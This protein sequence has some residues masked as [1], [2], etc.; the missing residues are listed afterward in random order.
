ML[1]NKNIIGNQR[2]AVAMITVIFIAII[3]TIITTSFIRLSI[4]EQRESTDDDL[5]TRA[6]YAAESGVQDAIAAIKNGTALAHADECRPE[7]GDGVLSTDLNTAY[8]CQKIDLTPSN[9]QASLGENKSVFFVLDSG[10]D[11]ITSFT[12]D[13]HM[14][15]DL[16]EGTNS[17]SRPSA[18]TGLPPKTDWHDLVD[19]TKSFPAMLRLQVL[20][21]PDG[22]T[23]R[24][25][26][27]NGNI[28]VSY[29]H[30]TLPTI[31]SV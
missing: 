14:Y 6:F 4:N 13:W 26:I 31:Y 20:E 2:G 16:G 3:L 28:A 25:D 17:V 23:T 30:L 15:G 19:S 11:N 10:A 27:D 9:Y 22:G 18:E 7:T 24:S 5:T 29:T 12:I 8:T 21:L 1:M